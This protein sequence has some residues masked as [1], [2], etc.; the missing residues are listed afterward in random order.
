M[1]LVGWFVGYLYFVNVE[2]CFVVGSGGGDCCFVV[3]LGV[4]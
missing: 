2:N 3:E 1:F 4:E